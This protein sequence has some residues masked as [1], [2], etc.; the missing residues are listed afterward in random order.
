MVVWNHGMG[1]QHA[2]YGTVPTMLIRLTVGHGV[3]Q[4][5]RGVVISPVDPTIE[6][7]PLGG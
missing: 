4:T 3:S 6:A 7:D 2:P 1:S 5:E